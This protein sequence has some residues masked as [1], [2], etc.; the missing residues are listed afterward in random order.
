MGGPPRH[1]VRLEG[2]RMDTL[3]QDLAY[4]FRRLR[5]APGFSL[6]AVATLALGIGANSTIFSVVNAVLLKPLPFSEPD[7]LV[8]VGQTWEG[9]FTR[10]Y[11]PQNFLDLAAQ[12]RSFESL[13]AIDG[14]GVTFT[15]R[16]A[17]ARIEGALV[18][19]NFFD[20]LRV[21]PL[22]GRGFLAGENETGK[23]KVAVLGHRLWRERFG[24]DPSV[25]GQT[26]QL[27]RD[28]YLVVGVAPPGFSYPEGTDLWRPLEHDEVF[29]SR[30]RGAWY[31]GVIGRLRPGIP[32]A[33]AREEVR[34]IAARLARAYPEANE[35][36]GGDVKPLHEAMVS[37][38]RNAL[39]V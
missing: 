13:A 27:D 36:V 15:G 24:S 19:A 33:Q 16:G 8:M 10:V 7:R 11:S 20:L 23:H 25:V 21:R 30:S 38:S 4:A 31:L 17:P 2:E 22:L 35:G 5:Q 26:I 34:V 6:V 39:L 29:R 18:S 28:S 3:R 37:D 1:G 32:L 12:A 14:G 9:R